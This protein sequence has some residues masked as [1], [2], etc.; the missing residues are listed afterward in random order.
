MALNI[1]AFNFEIIS[2]G[3]WIL[4]AVKERGRGQFHLT[5]V[6]I[7]NL[8]EFNFNRRSATLEY[9]FNTFQYELFIPILYCMY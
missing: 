2:N 8:P 7:Y 9:S 5:P 4:F 6:F 1:R 3:V